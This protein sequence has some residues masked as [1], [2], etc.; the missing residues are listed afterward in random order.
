MHNGFIFAKSQEAAL[1]KKLEF[2]KVGAAN[3]GRSLN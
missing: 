2:E 1:E 3:F